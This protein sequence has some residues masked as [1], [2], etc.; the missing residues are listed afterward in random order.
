MFVIAT[1]IPTWTL[2]HGGTTLDDDGETV[3]GLLLV[4]EAPSLGAAR[5][6]VAESPYGRA[7]LLADADVRP[8]NWM[9]GRPRLGRCG[10]RRRRAARSGRPLR[11]PTRAHPASVAVG[12]GLQLVVLSLAGTVLIPTMAIRAAG[13]TDAYLSWAVFWAITAGGACTALQAARLGRV[14][15][16]Y[17]LAMGPPRRLY[18]G[19][20]QRPR[21]G[22]PRPCSRPSSRRRRSSRSRSPCGSPCSGGS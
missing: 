18:R 14:G 19:L 17:V 22:R 12:C 4:V 13:G 10:E 6:F 21:R 2:L 16:G 11:A 3:N 5:A 20:R 7:G 8:W 1:V 9:T 15:A